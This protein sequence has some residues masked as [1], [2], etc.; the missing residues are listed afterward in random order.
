MYLL[1]TRYVPFPV[2]FGCLQTT[3]FESCLF[4]NNYSNNQRNK[5]IQT[6]SEA[7]Q[8]NCVTLV[9][10]G[11]IPCMYGT[12]P[13]RTVEYRIAALYRRTCTVRY[14]TIPY[15]TVRY[16]TLRYGTVH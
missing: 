12:I 1:R 4:P 8:P 13:Y 14:H 15:D 2:R 5:C 7:E 9:Q 10:Y 3:T 16:V 6:G 11:R